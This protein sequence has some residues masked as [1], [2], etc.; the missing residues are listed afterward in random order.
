MSIV[1]YMPHASAGVRLRATEMEISASSWALEARERLYFSLFNNSL[2]T[3]TSKDN[4]I[5]MRIE[6]KHLLSVFCMLLV[7]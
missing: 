2:I 4:Q 6:F 1:A 3:L 7:L 5:M